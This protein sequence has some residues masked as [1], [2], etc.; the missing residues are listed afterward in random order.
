MVEL[1]PEHQYPIKVIAQEYSHSEAHLRPEKYPSGTPGD[2]LG[3]RR[4]VPSLYLDIVPS[5]AP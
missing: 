5:K 3:L 4:I 2:L 1:H